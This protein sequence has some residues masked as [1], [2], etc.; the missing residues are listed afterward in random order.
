MSRN[1]RLDAHRSIRTTE[2]AR[3]PSAF[4]IAATM[5]LLFV[6]GLAL[7]LPDGASAVGELTFDECFGSAAPCINVPNKQ[8]DGAW[9]VAMD[10][11]NG[12]LYATA[13]TSKSILHFFSDAEGHLS[14][15]GCIS[16]D[17]SGGAGADAGSSANPFNVSEGLAIDSDRS[18]VFASSLTS[19]LVARLGAFPE[20]QIAYEGCISE[21]GS[22][23]ACVAAKSEAGALN[24]PG[25]LALSPSGNML[26][27]AGGGHGG[28]VGLVSQLTVAP[29]GALAYGGCVSSDGTSGFCED[30]PGG[31][32]V[33][34]NISG[35]A[36]NPVS[37]AVYTASPTD[38]DV[39]RFATDPG[40]QMHWRA[41]VGQNSQ[42]ATCATVPGKPEPSPLHTVFGVIASPDGHSLYAISTEGYV[43][44]LSVSDDGSIAWQGCVSDDGTRG[45]G[46]LPGSGTPLQEAR[47]VA[48]SP[49]G[50]SLYVI[51]RSAVTS[52]SLDAAGVPSFQG[53]L[54]SNAMSGCTDMPGAPLEGG[55]QVA[56]SS[57]GRSVYLTGSSSGTLIHLRRAQPEPAPEVKPAP[58]TNAT[59]STAT[60]IAQS[61]A[62]A[63]HVFTAAELKASLLAQLVPNG[64]NAKLSKVKKSKG[65]AQSFK[66]LVAGSLQLNWFFLPPGAHVSGAGKHKPKPKPVLFASGQA[67][68]PS[69]V[70]KTVSIKLTTKA[71]KLLGHRGTIKLTAKGTFTPKGATAV[72]A[73]KTFQL[74]G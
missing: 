62:A 64:K 51:G 55:E 73:T 7:M 40:G 31:D 47:G 74:K 4:L 32:S 68:F 70:A 38:S 56:V 29:N 25:Q 16:D 44:H 53:C 42:A 34:S 33:L 49:D 15:D 19:N 3:Q 27:V 59:T 45:C 22:G 58:T 12:A 21:N 63:T 71:L 24:G 5:A 13:T 8:L 39:S 61:V 18:A 14:Y 52:F 28:G 65:Y 72:S 2:M 60:A 1:A 50:K 6:A 54:S 43:S 23:G 30:V 10:P 48:V 37:A 26:Y 57:D 46:D 17:G 69:A 36:V 66:A 11:S 67:V 9:S 41:C 35:V 20:G